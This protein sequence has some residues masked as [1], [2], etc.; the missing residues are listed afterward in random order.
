[1]PALLGIYGFG[2]IGMLVFRAASANLDVQRPFIPHDYMVY[3]HKYDSVHGR[4]N[5][6]IAMS[7]E[8]REEFFVL[9]RDRK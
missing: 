4:F 8:D 1:M 7:E 6:T 2:R 5:G 9:K 3:L